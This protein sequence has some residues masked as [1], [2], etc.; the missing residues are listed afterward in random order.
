M[1]LA[2]HDVAQPPRFDVGILASD[3]VRYRSL[4][5]QAELQ[6]AAWNERADH[7]LQAIDGLDRLL[8]QLTGGVAQ[9]GG[10][11]RGV[12]S[13]P[14]S[15]APLAPGAAAAAA[16]VESPDASVAPSDAKA[17]RTAAKPR[18][19]KPA[20]RAASKAATARPPAAE[21]PAAQ[22][23]PHAEALVSPAPAGPATVAPEVRG[24]GVAGD[25]VPRGTD[26][27]R[28]VLASEPGRGWSLQDLLA[29]L[30]HRGWLPASRRPEEGI[31][32]GLKRLADRNLVS[33]SDDG[34]WSLS[35]STT[36]SPAEHA[37]PTAAPAS[38]VPDVLD[39]EAAASATK[40]W[41]PQVPEPPQPR[42]I[43]ER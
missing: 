38:D 6:V 27:I 43:Q 33:R 28:A 42:T 36:T 2:L 40:P 20:K 8:D 32:I 12:V 16:G 29:E 1:A 21:P 14:R 31:R 26:A 30:G 41:R 11:P 5:E 10:A 39:V 3:R 4:L 34:I 9:D 37:A 35:E 15:V 13:S 23:T 18:T 25:E 19:A 7:L 17:A 22:E 24:P